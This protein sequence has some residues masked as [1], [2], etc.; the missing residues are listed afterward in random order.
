M[1][2]AGA[3]AQAPVP[4]LNTKWSS[5]D[6]IKN[7]I[8]TRIGASYIF[9]DQDILTKQGVAYLSFANADNSRKVT[10][11]LYKGSV[12]GDADM[13]KPA[14]NVVRQVNIE[15]LFVDM[16]PVYQ[17]LFNVATPMDE[18]KTKG[19]THI[20]PIKEKNK[21]YIANF[22]RTGAGSGNWMLQIKE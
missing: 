14:T 17:K 22:S 9:K 21:I 1:F 13:G 8:A 20:E 12:G 6:S 18:V 10:V 11:T 15:G 19:Y 4:Y 16:F 3:F 7:D 5:I 2:A